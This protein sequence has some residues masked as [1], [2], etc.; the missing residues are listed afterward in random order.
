M[1]F[2]GSFSSILGLVESGKCMILFTLRGSSHSESGEAFS[3]I[4]LSLTPIQ[5][6]GL[7]NNSSFAGGYWLDS[8]NTRN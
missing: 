3:V 5:H 8:V 2:G 6:V 7:A 1:V 4:D